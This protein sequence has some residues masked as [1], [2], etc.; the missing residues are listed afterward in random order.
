MLAAS[1]RSSNHVSASLQVRRPVNFAFALVFFLFRQLVTCRTL[2]AVSFFLSGDASLGFAQPI[3][4]EHKK[5]A[6]HML[7]AVSNV[8]KVIGTEWLFFFAC[9]RLSSPLFYIS[10]LSPTYEVMCMEAPSPSSPLSIS[11][12]HPP[13][14]LR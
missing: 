6:G 4:L 13:S 8:M 12:S 5:Q 9:L 10:L 2:T 11:S 3:F 7:R 14:L 1:L